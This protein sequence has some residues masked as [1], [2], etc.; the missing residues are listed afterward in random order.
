MHDNDAN[1]IYIYSI[2]ANKIEL[3]YVNICSWDTFGFRVQ[4]W[5]LGVL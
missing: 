5:T 2:L 1:I 3:V 4:V